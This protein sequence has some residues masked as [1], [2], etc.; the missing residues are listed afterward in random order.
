MEPEDSWNVFYS[1]NTALGILL[2]CDKNR[3]RRMDR[4]T[5]CFIWL[6]CYLL[7][8]QL[9]LKYLNVVCCRKYSNLNMANCLQDHAN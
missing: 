4:L 7:V 1:E 6:K 5:S 8:T 9:I 2:E 3:P